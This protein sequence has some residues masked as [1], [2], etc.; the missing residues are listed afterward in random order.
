MI[1]R[2]LWRTPFRSPSSSYEFHQ[3]L[4]ATVTAATA[5]KQTESNGDSE[6]SKSETTRR[7][8]HFIGLNFNLYLNGDCFT[9]E[10]RSR[11]WNENEVGSV[12]TTET[13]RCELC[14]RYRSRHSQV[15]S[16]TELPSS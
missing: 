4:V 14:G 6:K 11:R 13:E 1:P 10:E 2:R 12:G 16:T 9:A 7:A 5:P 15:P 3:G 8:V